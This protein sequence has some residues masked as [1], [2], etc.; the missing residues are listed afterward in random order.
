MRFESWDRLGLDQARAAGFVL[1]ASAVL[2][3]IVATAGSQLGAGAGSAIL[4]AMAACGAAYL[5]ATSPRRTIRAAAFQQTLESPSL[6]ASS[7]IFLKATGSRS[8]TLLMVRSEEP[9]L[10]AFLSDLRRR[11]LLGYDA[12][13]AARGADPSRHLFSE[14]AT[15]IVDSVVGAD[16]AWVD[17]GGEELD[18]ILGS[19]GLDDETKL[20]VLMAVAFFVPIMLVLFAAIAKETGP[21][22]VAALFVV[23]L[24]IVDLT[25]AASSSAAGWEGEGE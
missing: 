2:F 9:L 11:V 7:N 24:V 12:P 18:M 21:V 23:E 19:S 3:L 20:P 6:A 17:E 13:A 22:S 4:A 5:L 1:T 8:K 25:L 10:R 14:S 16:R 15:A